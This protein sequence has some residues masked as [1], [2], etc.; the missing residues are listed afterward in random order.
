MGDVYAGGVT[1]FQG[2][3]PPGRLRPSGVDELFEARAEFDFDE[4]LCC[5]GHAW[6]VA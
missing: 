4:L 3:A 6:T 1:Q 5:R 2:D